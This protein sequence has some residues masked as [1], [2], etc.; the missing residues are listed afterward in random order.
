MSGKT[1]IFVM[2]YRGSIFLLDNVV[3]FVLVSVLFMDV[4]GLTPRIAEDGL[5]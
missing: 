2:F 3:I 4:S 5:L 1:N